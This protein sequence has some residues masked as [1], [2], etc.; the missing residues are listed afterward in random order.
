MLWHPHQKLW[1]WDLFSLIQRA[2]PITVLNRFIFSALIFIDTSLLFLSVLARRVRKL[3]LRKLFYRLA[4]PDDVPIIY[5]DMGTH[6]EGLELELMA[7]KILPTISNNYTAYGFE[8]N[9]KSFEE[10][11]KSLE[12]I[13]VFIF[14]IKL[15]VIRRL[16]TGL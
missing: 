14:I 1:N 12:K 8:A 6:K 15:Y 5:F 2:I 16:P 7:T 11:S 3:G 10:V 9:K 13:T 4:T